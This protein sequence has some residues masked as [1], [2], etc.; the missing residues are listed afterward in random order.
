VPA[1]I[2]YTAE[3]LPLVIA[4]QLIEPLVIS[5]SPNKDGGLKIKLSASTSRHLISIGSVICDCFE[6]ISV[7]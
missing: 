1:F 4:V 3:I 5:I 6:L 7:V 2:E